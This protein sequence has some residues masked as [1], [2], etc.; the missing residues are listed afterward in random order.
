MA[1]PPDSG[2]PT[3]IQRL[4]RRAAVDEAFRRELLDAPARVAAADPELTPRERAVLAA[5]PPAQLAAMIASVRPPVGVDRRAFVRAASSVLLLGGVAL[6]AC[7]TL[8]CGGIGPDVPPDDGGPADTAGAF[9]IV[10][11]S[12]P[13]AQ[14]GE[15]YQATVR[16]RDGTSPVAFTITAQSLA[17]G[18]T[19]GEASGEIHGYPT[20]AGLFGFDVQ[21][22][23]ADQQ[24]ATRTLSIS[25]AEAADGGPG[26]GG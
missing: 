13:D 7:P 5:V 3:G 24:V 6:T 8:T 18:L 2:I 9:A 10:T 4:V 11:S 19:L 23:S 26:D 1:T 14:L 16:T 20:Q 15:W 17:A 25:V 21:A 22:T 12:L